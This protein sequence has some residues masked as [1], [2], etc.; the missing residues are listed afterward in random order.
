MSWWFRRS[1]VGSDESELEGEYKGLSVDDLIK[2]NP[3]ISCPGL[4]TAQSS[5]T[6]PATPGPS[7][8]P[9]MPGLVENCDGFYK[10]TS[11]NKCD[12]IGISTAQFRSWNSYINAGGLLTVETKPYH[13]PLLTSPTGCSYLWLGYYVCVHVA[14][15]MPQMPGVVENCDGFHKVVS[16]D[17]CST[18]V[19]KYGIS[20]AQFMGWNT[21]LNAQCTNLWLDYYVC[22]H[23]PNLGSTP[24]MPGVAENCKRYH[25]IVSG[26]QCSTIASRYG[27]ST[28]QFLSYNSGVN[29]QCTNLWLGYYVC[30]GA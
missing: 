22:I 27:I 4:D 8:F 17:Q 9:A 20:T 30:V 24:Q 14:G 11:S 3:G 12:I 19:Q 28:A 13:N 5:S 29:A 1:D 21:Q 18:I 16:G 10:V 7:N 25:L 23:V 26:D 2:L 15:P 6:T